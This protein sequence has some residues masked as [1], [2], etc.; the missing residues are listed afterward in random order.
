[1]STDHPTGPRDWEGASYDTLSTPQRQM[2]GDVLERLRPR[3]RGDETVLDAGCGSGRVTAELLSLVPEGRVIG[4]D[5]SPSMIEQA[6]RLLPAS[7]ELHVQ[8]LAELLLAVPVD[9]IVSTAT[10]HWLPDHERL[11]ARLAAALRPGAPFEAQCG[12]A[13]NIASVD[14]A[15]ERLRSR[16]PWDLAPTGWEGPW[17]FATP[18]DTSVRLEGAGFVDVR[19]WLEPRPVALPE[20]HEHA[21]LRTVVLGSHLERLPEEAHDD[22]V[23]AV[24][25]E[26]RVGGPGHPPGDDGG[27]TLD[28]VRLNISATRAGGADVVETEDEIAARLRGG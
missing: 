16:A 27:I 5:G 22:F 17:N 19:C 13:G 25:E 15:I 23:E 20:E 2:G 6:R 3:L 18:E 4:V 9:A 10:F 12:G 26:L 1:M 11:F 14:A 8:D 24:R 28:Y 21:Y 7:V